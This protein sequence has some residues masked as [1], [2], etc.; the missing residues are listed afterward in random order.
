MDRD[1][2]KQLISTLVKYFISSF[3]N[4][5]IAVHLRHEDVFA[6]LQ[7][8]IDGADA[9]KRL[10]QL[11]L[12]CAQNTGTGFTTVLLK[13]RLFVRSNFTSRR[14]C[15]YNSAIISPAPTLEY[16]KL[17]LEQAIYPTLLQGLTALCK[18][19]PANPTVILLYPGMARK[20]ATGK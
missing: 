15:F 10:Q 16:T 2:F 20:L 7:S 19:K 6:T 17:F 12:A 13:R 4:D 8:H 3:R 18:E 11:I 5:I 14:V 9:T 1:D